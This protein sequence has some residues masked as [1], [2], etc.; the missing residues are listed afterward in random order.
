MLSKKG[1]KFCNSNRMRVMNEYYLFNDGFFSYYINKQTGE[2]KFKLD[3]NDK[4]VLAEC[5]DFTRE[6]NISE[7]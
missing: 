3:K 1:K 6:I 5:D 2:K 7:V 4:L